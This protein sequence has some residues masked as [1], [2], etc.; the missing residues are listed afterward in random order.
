MNVTVDT[1]KQRRRPNRSDSLPYSGWNAV[2]VMRYDVVSQAALFAASNSELM[3][4]YVDAVMVM[5]N[6]D[7]NTLAHKAVEA[8]SVSFFFFQFPLC[9][10]STKWLRTNLNPPEPSPWLPFFFLIIL[11]ERL[12]KRLG[13]LRLQ[14]R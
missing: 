13:C 3:A 10:C 5:S 9:S 2:L 4:A 7:R 6:P 11:G 8:R 12:I 1:K 14:E